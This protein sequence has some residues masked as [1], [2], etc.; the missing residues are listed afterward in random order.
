MLGPKHLVPP[1]VVAWG[2]A[3]LGNHGD[4]GFPVKAMQWGLLAYSP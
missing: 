2:C 4:L 3:R 1:T